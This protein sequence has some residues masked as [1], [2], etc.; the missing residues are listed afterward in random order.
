MKKFRIKHIVHRTPH[1]V[2]GQWIARGWLI[3]DEHG[4]INLTPGG[5][6]FTTLQ[7]AYLGVEALLSSGGDANPGEF[8]RVYRK[9]VKHQQLSMERTS[10][11]CFYFK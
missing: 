5:G 8:H 10:N 2:N 7:R 3:C 11:V 6:W 9:L 4:F 1:L